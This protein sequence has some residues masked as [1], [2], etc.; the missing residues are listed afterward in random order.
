MTYRRVSTDRQDIGLDAQQASIDIYRTM[1]G[2][3]VNHAFTDEGVS[4]SVPLGERLEGRRLLEMA[5]PGSV[6]IA[7]KLDRLFRSVADAAVTL[8][9]WQR[10]SIRV[11]AIYE[12]FDMRSPMGRAMAQMASVFAEL[13]RAMIWERTIAALAVKRANGQRISRDPP[14]GWDAPDGRTLIENPGEQEAIEYMRLWRHN[15]DSLRVIAS[16]LD[17]QGVK[18][19]RGGKWCFSSVAHILDRA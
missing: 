1:H 11:V 10:L 13:E 2:L 9:Q 18:P 4:G 5:E 15:G 3:P 17:G 6:V 12:G 16:R 14:F 8:D 7:A 19:K